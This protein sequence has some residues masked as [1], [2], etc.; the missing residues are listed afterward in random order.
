MKEGKIAVIGLGIMG[1]SMAKGL[2]GFHGAEIVGCDSNPATRRA[3]LECGAVG[4]VYE[5]A[6]DAIDGADLVILCVYPDSIV[7]II[8]ENGKRFKRGAV[9]TDICGVKSEISKDIA[10]ALPSGTDYVGGHPMAGREVSGFENSE[11]ELFWNT[12]YII[13][14]LE[15]S[16]RESVDLIFEMAQYIGAKYITVNSPE[17]HDEVIAYTSD[18]MHVASAALCLDFNPN[19]NRAYTAGSFRD[20][21]RIANI[22]PDLWTELFLRNRK[23]VLSE[24]DRFSGSINTLRAA[25]EAEDAERIHEILSRVRDNKLYMDKKEPKEGKIK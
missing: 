11:A 15:S 1:G 6:G 25:I 17:I 2:R 21:T 18:L 4:R 5:N 8:R 9:I 3:A 13:C 24:I 10:A 14:P 20:C 19:M 12:G 7:P 22:N 16:K 23:N